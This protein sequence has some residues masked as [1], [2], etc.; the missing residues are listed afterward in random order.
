V[1][2]FAGE[3]SK[4]YISGSTACLASTT[5]YAG[6]R[7]PGS[8]TMAVPL[9]LQ[10]RYYRPKVPAYYRLVGTACNNA[11]L[12]SSSSMERCCC[13]EFK[14]AGTTALGISAQD[15]GRMYYCYEVPGYYRPR[16]SRSLYLLRNKRYWPSRALVLPADH[17][18]LKTKCWPVLP[19]GSAILPPS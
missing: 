6:W 4:I 3:S 9:N 2:E 16:S 7:L 17:L 15:K 19:L 10:E 11:F 12:L 5:A 1:F 13:N 8:S 14:A 18:R